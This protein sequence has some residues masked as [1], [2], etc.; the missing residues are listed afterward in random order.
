V[1]WWGCGPHLLR[2][3]NG[4]KLYFKKSRENSNNDTERVRVAATA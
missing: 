3:A 4:R 2:A 1:E